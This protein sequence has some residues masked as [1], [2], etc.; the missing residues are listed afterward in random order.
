[1]EEPSVEE[2]AIRL[3]VLVGI[4]AFVIRALIAGLREPNPD[5]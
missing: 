1:V 4:M 5:K 2:D 3:I